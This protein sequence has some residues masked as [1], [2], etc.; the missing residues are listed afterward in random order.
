MKGGTGVIWK[1]DTHDIQEIPESKLKTKINFTKQKL[2]M[3]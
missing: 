2:F 3:I 1:S